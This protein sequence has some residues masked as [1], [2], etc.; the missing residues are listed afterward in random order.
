MKLTTIGENL[1]TAERI[2]KAPKA[3]HAFMQMTKFDIEN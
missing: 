3:M 1:A 2:V